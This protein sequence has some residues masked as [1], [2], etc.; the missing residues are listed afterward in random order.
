VAFGKE[1]GKANLTSLVERKSR[2]LLLARNPG[3]HSA[4]V[5]SGI[6]SH[7]G[8]LPPRARRSITFDRGTEFAFFSR[9]KS[10]LGIDSWFCKPQAPW[11][12]VSVENTTDGSGASCPDRPTWRPSPIGICGQL[13][14]RSTPPRASASASDRHKRFSK[15]GWRREPAEPPRISTGIHNHH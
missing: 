10:D 11:Q 7:L 15:N 14:T 5:M 3:R 4:G 1:F 12:K 2:Y 8:K 13:V 9:L 6:A